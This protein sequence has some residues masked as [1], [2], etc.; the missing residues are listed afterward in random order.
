MLEL[1]AGNL[2]D[3]TF[4]ELVEILN[5]PANVIHALDNNTQGQAATGIQ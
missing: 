5:L 1:I 3:Y 2:L 4:D